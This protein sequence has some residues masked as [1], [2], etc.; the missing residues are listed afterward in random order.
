MRIIATDEQFLKGNSRKN[1]EHT[2]KSS[3]ILNWQSLKTAFKNVA[4]FR[5]E[6]NCTMKNNV[7]QDFYQLGFHWIM[8]KSLRT[9]PLRSGP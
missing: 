4:Y 6:Q 3:S 7:K 1:M 2:K 9:G 5:V 8:E